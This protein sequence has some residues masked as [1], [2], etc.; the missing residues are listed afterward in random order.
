MQTWTVIIGN[1]TQADLP[2][3]CIKSSMDVSAIQTITLAGNEQVRGDLPPF[4]AA[5]APRDVIGKNLACR[6]V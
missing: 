1:A 2:G 5:F 6:C 4:P 3:Q